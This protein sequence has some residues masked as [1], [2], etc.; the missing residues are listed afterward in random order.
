M[1]EMLHVKIGDR[2][3]W[4]EHSK[5]TDWRYETYEGCVVS[6]DDITICV[7]SDSRGGDY[8]RLYWV[9]I[10][11]AFHDHELRNSVTMAREGY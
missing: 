11:K 2:V 7:S 4:D 6:F 5:A 9:Q 8:P 1:I 3:Y 10:E